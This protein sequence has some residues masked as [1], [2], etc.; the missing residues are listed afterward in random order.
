MHNP[1][2]TTCTPLRCGYYGAKNYQ[3][4]HTLCYVVFCFLNTCWRLAVFIMAE[5]LTAQVGLGDFF[6]T[7]WAS[8][9]LQAQ[10]QAYSSRSYGPAAAA[11]TVLG[12]A[13]F[14]QLFCSR[15]KINSCVVVTGSIAARLVNAEPP[16]SFLSFAIAT[17]T[18][19][20]SVFL[21]FDVAEG[22]CSQS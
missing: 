20:Q 21:S 17:T 8:Y 22:P 7:T 4:H 6:T 1:K 2:C 13:L 11:S 12:L 14:H 15:N 5:S 16:K 18:N 10:T 3:R 9:W 19:R